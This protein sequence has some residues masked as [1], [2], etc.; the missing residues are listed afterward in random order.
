LRGLAASSGEASEAEA[1][2][3]RLFRLDRDEGDEGS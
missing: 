1:L 2:A 3:R